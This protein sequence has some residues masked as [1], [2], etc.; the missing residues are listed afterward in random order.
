MATVNSIA[1]KK[2]ELAP[3]GAPEPL[4]VIVS[5]EATRVRQPVQLGEE[6]DEATS[7]CP[8][9][10]PDSGETGDPSMDQQVTARQQFNQATEKSLQ[11][12]TP[13]ED[14]M[15]RSFTLPILN[16]DRL[17]TAKALVDKAVKKHKVFS[18]QGPYPIVRAALR[19]RGWVERRM[20]SPN[21]HVY[22]RHCDQNRKGS[23]ANDADDSGDD[24]CELDENNPGGVEKE[25]DSDGMYDIMCRLVRNEMVYFYW[26]NRRE[27]IDTHTLQKEQITN[28]FAKAGSFTTK[29]GLCVNLRN[30]RWFDSSN[31]DTFFPRCYMLGAED[32]R[33]AFI[34]DYRRTACSSLLQCIV[35]RKQGV[36]GEGQKGGKDQ[37][38]Q[39]RRKQ[40]KRRA[41]PLVPS[42]IIDSALKICQEFLDSLEHNDI[43]ISSEKPQ[44]LTK[45]QWEEFINN[46]YLVVHDGAEI[47]D[48]F[49]FVD[50]CQVM[51]QR[52]REVSPQ[53]NTDGIH[54]I[55]IVKPGAKS[56][57]RGITCAKRL[58]EILR[59]VNSDL[60][61]IKDNKW[62][63][64]KY[65]ERPLLVHGTKFDV[66]QWFLVTDWNPLT[67][68]FYKKCYLRFSTRPYSLDTM[69]SSVHLC[70]N[71]IQKHLQPS[72]LR[73]PDIPADNMW[74]CDQFR[75][76]LSSQGLAA[77]W[78][79]VVVS[80]MKMA[81]IHALQT[82]QDLVESRKSTF[83]L[84]GADFMLGPDLHPW[85]IEINASPTMVP[86]TAVTAR[87]CTA[88]QEDTLRV[89]LDRRGDRTANT[90]GFQ[91][92]YKQPI[93]W[94]LRRGQASVS[95]A[96]SLL[97]A[98]E[99]RLTALDNG[100]RIAS[101]ETGDAT[102]TVGLWID[103]G[104]RYESEKNNGTGFFLEH[105]AFKGTKKYPQ[106]ALE[107]QVESMGGHLSAYTSREHT[108]FYM[109]TL[110]KDLP[111]A[112]ELLSEVVQ[113]NALSEAEIEQQRGVV[114]RE[115]EEVEG[116]L[117]EVCLDLLHA[118]AF[119]GT[120][121]GHSVI[122]PSNNARVLT[123][124]DLVDYINSHYKAPRMVLAAAGGVNHE[125]LV[126]LAKTHFSGMSF[127]YEGDAVPVLSPCRFTGSEVRMRDDALPLAHVAIAVE[128]ASAASPD[129]VPLKVANAII[130][131]Y[132]VTYGGGKN[133]SSR[134]ARLAVEANLCHS[135]QAFHSCYSDTGLLGIYFVT[136]KHYI[137][138]M[139]HW[140][141]NAWMNLC[142][143]VT[144]SDVARGK[145]ALKAS[146]V[147]H[148]N[149]TTPMC[150]DIGKHILHYGR[151]I[152]LAEWDARIDA[153]TPKMVRDVCSK[154]IYDKCPAVAAVG[155]VEQLPDYNRV[156][157]AMYWLRF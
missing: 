148:L 2:H 18:I 30:L 37:P 98:P 121:L 36:Q 134:L 43:D 4:K 82:T 132:D 127:E 9:S 11:P 143:T 108:A 44:S 74:S 122:G 80:G 3:A 69:D 118:T 73:H 106:T 66:R 154:Y 42:K 139:M 110:A 16:L 22:R 52:L 32:E 75:V 144:E 78:E 120:A 49:G 124:Q 51:L 10:R 125:E 155:P 141:Q 88:V 5:M 62:V 105:M 97:G 34:E 131:S 65:L 114:L 21:Q 119:Q 81:V 102:C 86:S 130:G 142:T 1:L 76:F 87:L 91:L 153:V 19:A 103:A 138:D 17:R 64:Q 27:T 59:L 67:V 115:L 23:A 47:E 53:L 6:G 111:K 126:G 77:Q 58:D 113:S 150:D 39:N 123:R 83:E 20:P 101:E 31:P 40:C 90:G 133:L 152:P 156:R 94:S 146:L 109:K 8:T 100:L 35:E 137:E 140:S 104:S 145:N 70:N 136:D 93:L 89:V 112:V 95:Y 57:G 46:Y 50:R 33:H 92:I 61:L 135:F 41:T 13:P 84:Y 55:W 26:T 45:E 72:Q 14:K 107:Q 128:G 63:V 149:G 129:I 25:D 117:Q 56:R 71:S 28:H 147:G 38:N 48:S 68:W 24:D 99:T 96:Q 54:N 116:N 79:T 12:M 151:R 60:A 7:G 15:C 85:L 157:S 29:V